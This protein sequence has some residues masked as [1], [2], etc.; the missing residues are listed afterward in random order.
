MELGRR[1][2]LPY[3][4]TLADRISTLGLEDR[5]AVQASCV[6]HACKAIQVI[7]NRDAPLVPAPWVNGFSLVIELRYSAS[8]RPL[9]RSQVSGN[10]NISTSSP[11]SKHHTL[12]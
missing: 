5:C 10:P 12:M 1:R 7:I 2:D 8:A 9:P 3:L 11:M 6:L 4:T